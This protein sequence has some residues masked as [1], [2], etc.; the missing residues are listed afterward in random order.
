MKKLLERI[1]AFLKRPSRKELEKRIKFLQA[2]NVTLK[3]ENR[4][5]KHDEISF[6]KK[7]ASIETINIQRHVPPY[8][9]RTVEKE[10]IVKSM[11]KELS[12]KLIDFVEVEREYEGLFNQYLITI[13]LA[14]AK[15]KE[16]E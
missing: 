8:I 4:C 6:I 1:K 13:K 7:Y 12:A 16:S 15:R 14:V 11:I 2:E 9:M 3:A 5:L 10:E